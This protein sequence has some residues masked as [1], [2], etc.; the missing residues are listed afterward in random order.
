LAVKAVEGDPRNVEFKLILG[1][2]YQHA[3]LTKK[4]TTVFER[5]LELDSR[6]EEA[7]Q[8]LKKL[9]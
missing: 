9:K 2:I 7:K 6:N 1:R 4:A 3:K 5:V 8:A